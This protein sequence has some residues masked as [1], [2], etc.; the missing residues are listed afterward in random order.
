MTAEEQ[1]RF[2][3]RKQAV[4][5]KRNPKREMAWERVTMIGF[6]TSGGLS[7]YYIDDVHLCD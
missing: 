2:D 1:F 4:I 6:F 5:R 3:L 7:D